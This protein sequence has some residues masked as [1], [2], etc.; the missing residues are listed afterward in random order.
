MAALD[1]IA[2]RLGTTPDRLLADSGG[3]WTRVDADLHLAAGRH[4]E[5]ADAYVDLADRAV[6]PRARGEL[7]LGAGEAYA[8]M[9]KSHEA[10]KPL[11]EA[12]RL[13]EQS[14]T[15]ADR[16]RAR[17]WLAWVH[18]SL[19]DV[20]DAR[21]ILLGLLDLDLA[22]I[23]DPD[24]ELRIR[25]ALAS[26]EATHGSAEKATLYLE[27]AR[28]DLDRLDVRRRAV[29]FDVLTRAREQAGDNEGAIRAGLEAITLYRAAEQDVDVAFLENQLALCYLRLGS[30]S[31][32]DELITRAESTSARS[33][34]PDG[35]GRFLD[36]KAM[37]RLAQGD[38]A[39]ALALADR[40]IEIE[41]MH[42]ESGT[43]TGARVSRA[44]AL[45]ALGR[46]DEAE[47]AWRDAASSART[48]GSPSRRK[49][50]F[51]AW[52]ETLA[53]QGRHAEAYEVMREAL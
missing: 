1:Y 29:Y 52:A 34:D 8:R 30:I 25:I 51:A 39:A 45:A 11:I 2:P 12:D 37:V 18:Q 50:V 43:Q 24:M 32:A 31:R 48:L 40:A 41:R 46:H 53:S 33:G 23:G 6:D 5:A 28:G 14:G 15:L 7:L 10:T 19:D 4:Q 47:A 20:D 27:E 42:E 9:R 44:Q 21:R 36:T 13:L 49:A 17:Y 3:R 26:I 22:S 16:V 38:P 35:L